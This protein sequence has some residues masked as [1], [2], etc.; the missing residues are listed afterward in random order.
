MYIIM[1]LLFSLLCRLN[2]ANWRKIPLLLI[3]V[4]KQDLNTSISKYES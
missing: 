3:D 1:I 4:I 2:E